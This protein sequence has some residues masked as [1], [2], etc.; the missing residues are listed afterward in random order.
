MIALT[1]NMFCSEQPM[2]RMLISSSIFEDPPIS[3]L[4]FLF[5]F[6]LGSSASL[7]LGY[8]TFLKLEISILA[9]FF[10]LKNLLA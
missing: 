6:P 4:T 2:E 1:H 7:S 8:F 9:H 3:V 5:V 10:K